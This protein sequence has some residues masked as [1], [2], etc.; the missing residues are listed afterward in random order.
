MIDS[1]K[2][3]SPPIFLAPLPHLQPL[4]PR[5]ELTTLQAA[6]N[7]LEQQLEQA[8]KDGQEQRQLRDREANE[9]EVALAKLEKENKEAKDAMAE[10]HEGA[11]GSVM[12][13]LQ[14]AEQRV[15]DTEEMLAGHKALLEEREGKIAKLSQ[16]ATEQAGKIRELELEMKN[17]REEIAAGKQR[18][19]E[20]EKNVATLKEK[21][22]DL[23]EMISKCEDEISEQTKEARRQ[24]RE[25]EEQAAK[26]EQAHKNEIDTLHA[27]HKQAA[28]AMQAEF[29]EVRTTLEEK[30]ATL[31]GDY[32]ALEERFLTRESRPEDIE[33]IRQLETVLRTKD[34]EIAAIKE[35][36]RYFKLELVNREEN[37]KSPYRARG[38]PQRR[39]R[40]LAIV[41]VR[42]DVMRCD[43]V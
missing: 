12:E 33:R 11:I 13:K 14:A 22:A 1:G 28:D 39:A 16:Q 6:K 25:N 15:R 10:A 37:C 35:E 4:T 19:G 21:I 41:E 24:R 2:P 31:E 23:N 29:D 26:T 7:G 5:R 36:M 32:S 17:S 42:G 3:S 43:T 34:E 30:L 40:A 20:L 8:Q 18:E 27:E 9:H 38:G